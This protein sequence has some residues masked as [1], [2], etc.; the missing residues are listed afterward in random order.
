MGPPHLVWAVVG[1]VSRAHAAVVDHL[2]EALV[3]VDGGVDGADVLAG[4]ALAVHAHQSLEAHPGVGGIVADEI[5]V[6]ANPF[7]PPPPPP[8]PLPTHGNIVSHLTP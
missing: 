5:A 4:R 3:A 2:V 1:A 8:P 7:H 6:H